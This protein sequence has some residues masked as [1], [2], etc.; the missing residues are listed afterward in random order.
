MIQT[1]QRSNCDQ[2]V[3][4]ALMLTGKWRLAIVCALGLGAVSAVRENYVGCFLPRRKRS[5]S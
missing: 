3:Q 4:A 1:D 5:F 2:V